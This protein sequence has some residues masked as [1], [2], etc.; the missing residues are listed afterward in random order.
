[1]GPSEYGAQITHTQ[2]AA[3]MGTITVPSYSVVLKIRLA[4]NSA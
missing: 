2:E 4:N 3:P 1:M